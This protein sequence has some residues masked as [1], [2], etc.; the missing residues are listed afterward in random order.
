MAIELDSAG[1][2]INELP[3]GV[4]DI[5]VGAPTVEGIIALG[6]PPS[7][8]KNRPKYRIALSYAALNE[9]RPPEN[10]F[11]SMHDPIDTPLQAYY[12]WQAPHPNDNTL[13]YEPLTGGFEVVK[14]HETDMYD[15]DIDRKLVKSTHLLNYFV[16]LVAGEAAKKLG[17]EQKYQAH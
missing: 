10:F 13:F 3:A 15:V 14:N 8:L 17:L 7:T 2:L 4:V 12:A 5:T 6:L 1:T 9:G 16:G 11:I